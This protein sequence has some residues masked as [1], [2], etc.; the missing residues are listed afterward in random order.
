MYKTLV[1]PILDHLDSEKWHKNVKE[2]LHYSEYSPVSL[3]ALE[4]FANCSN[5]VNDKRLNVNLGGIELENPLVVGAGWDKTGRA[6]KALYTIGFAGVEVGS[7]LEHPQYG[8]PKPRQHMINS[9]V[10]LNW[11][12]FNSPGMETV[13]ENLRSYK[14]SNIPVGISLGINKYV[15]EKDAPR[16]HAAVA[17]RLY[18]AA[19]YFAINVSSP[20]TPGLRKL[21]NREQLEDIVKAVMEVTKNKEIKKPIFVKIAPELS[22]DLIDDVIKLVLDFGISGIIATNSTNNPSIRSKYG[23]KW[24]NKPGGLSGNDYEYKKLSTR[25]ISHIYKQAGNK[26]EIIGVG[27]INDAESAIE[28]LRAG[29]K[30]LQIVTGLRGEGLSIVSNINKGLLKF[31]KIKG[32]NYISDLTGN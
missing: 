20:N 12:G 13:S 3:K 22:Y 30:A 6:V 19:S 5:R 25:I 4:L 10:C 27:G 28:K 18:N 11:L 7:V 17:E 2:L 9:E 29:A 14:D 24:L 8:N 26:L 16:S 23:E 32:L 31:I 21:Q 1:R 15:N